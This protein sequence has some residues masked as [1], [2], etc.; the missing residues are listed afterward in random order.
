MTEMIRLG[1]RLR[2]ARK[3]A[4][5]K[6]SKD[7]L[8]KFKIP[9]STYSQHES[10][11]RTPDDDTLKFYSKALGVNFNWLLAGAGQPFKNIN[12]IKK[13]ILAEELIDL[14]NLDSNSQILVNQKIA[15]TSKNS[16]NITNPKLVAKILKELLNIQGICLSDNAAKSIAQETIKIYKRI[17][18]ST[19]SQNTQIKLLNEFFAAYK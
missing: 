17:T 12:Q 18:S 8:K 2:A 14:K 10:G 3:A 13:T 11:S 5:F 1:A 9:A 15:S 6:T 16:L 4:G 19:S 7:F